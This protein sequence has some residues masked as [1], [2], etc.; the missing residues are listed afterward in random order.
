GQGSDPED[1]FA[2]DGEDLAAGGQYDGIRAPG[3]D[4]VGQCG[5]GSDEVLAVVENEQQT[6]VAEL[7]AEGLV[8]RT[9]RS[10]QDT[11]I[12]A[13]RGGDSGADKSG[14]T[15]RRQFG[16]PDTVGEA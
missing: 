8:E 9:P 2:G 1:G 4:G 14:V 12:E 6:P 15:H 13:H 10:D 7:V 5:G 16:Q 11:G 3:E